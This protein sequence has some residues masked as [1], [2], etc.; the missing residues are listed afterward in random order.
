MAPG[1]ESEERLHCPR[2]QAGGPH[3]LCVGMGS[4]RGH[5]RTVCDTPAGSTQLPLVLPR[6]HET[7]CALPPGRGPCR[8]PCRLCG[9][10]GREEH[11][12]ALPWR[13]R[14]YSSEK[15]SCCVQDLGQGQPTRVRSS[16]TPW[17]R[18]VSRS[19]FMWHP[20]PNGKLCIF[21][22]THLCLS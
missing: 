14:G 11:T 8:R 16:V 18:P 19:S 20:P 17:D 1:P 9:T 22:S 7:E 2:G 13:A 4:P 21:L 12:S 3:V 15:L 6:V 5:R 10:V